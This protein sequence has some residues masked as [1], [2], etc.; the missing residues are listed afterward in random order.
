MFIPLRTDRD[1][2]RRPAVTEGL[3]LINVLVYLAGVAGQF[4]GAFDL[5]AMV[6]FGHFNKH[7]FQFW[8]LITYQFL[9]DPSSIWHLA[10][11]MLFLWVFGG[12]VEDRMTRV[13]FLLFYLM[14]GIFAALAHAMFSDAT[15]IG[16]SGSIA[17][18]TGAFLALFPR[19]HIRVL[20]FLTIISIPSL[21]FIGLYFAIDLMNQFGDWLGASSQRV[22]YMAHIAGYIYGFGLAFALLGLRVI[23]R[24]EYDV[25]FLFKQARRRAAFR[26]AQRASRGAVWDKTHLDPN[27][28]VPKA[29]KKPVE[30][31]ELEKRV[32]EKRLE[33][34]RLLEDHLLAPAAAKYRELL[35]E[36]PNTVFSEQR[37]V[38]LAN[39]LYKDGEHAHAAAAYELL[40]DSYPGSG[41]SGEVSLILGLIYARRLNRPQ[42]ARELIE[43][44]KKKLRDAAQISLA[45]QL[46]TELPS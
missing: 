4:F 25:F 21:W 43:V 18:V 44:A 31:T 27:R 34:T 26:D 30:L 1:P 3:I 5:G 6:Q 41:H 32:A 12:A 13:G 33:I 17:G 45:D 16:A 10:F 39:Q 22:A 24:E 38:D 20:F 11:N 46:L 14:A 9:H 37:Q 28:P 8:Q 29:P 23:K 42:R 35:N 2:R 15:I 7:D 40:L 19:S 36:A